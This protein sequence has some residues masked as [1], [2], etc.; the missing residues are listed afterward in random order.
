M[1]LQVQRNLVFEAEDFGQYLNGVTAN[2]GAK[3][4]VGQNR[5][6][7]TNDYDI[8]AG[9][10]PCLVPHHRCRGSAS[11]PPSGAEADRSGV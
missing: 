6:L 4:E 7:S 11:G 2:G 5:R 8:V 1:I 10:L 3:C 9:R